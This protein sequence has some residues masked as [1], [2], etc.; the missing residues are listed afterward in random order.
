MSHSPRRRVFLCNPPSGLYRRDDRCQS[1][2]EDQTVRVIF[3]PIDLALLAAIAR[4][5][6]AAVLLRDYPAD[7]KSDWETL[8]RDIREFAPDLVL[9]N[10]TS[11]T[12]EADMAVVRI[13]REES[14]TAL[15]I[16]RGEHFERMGD[17]LFTRED[18]P[19][20]ALH[21]EIEEN[22]DALLGGAPP[23]TLS[24]VLYRDVA[25]GKFRRKPGPAIVENLDALPIPAREFLDN[26]RYL[27]PETGRPITVILANRGCPSKCVYCPAGVLSGHRLRARSPQSVVGEI[28][29]C[30]ERHGVREFLFNGDTFTMNRKW[31]LELC[32]LI[33]EARLDIRWGCNSRVDTMDEERAAALKSAGCWVVAFGV[34]SG[35]QEM[36]DRMKKGTRLEQARRAI[37]VCKRAGLATHAFF[38]IGLPWENRE[39]LGRTFR[40]A[41]ELDTDFFD[42]NIAHPLPGTEF[43]EIAKAENLIV[44]EGDYAHAAVRTLYLSAE[45]LTR[46]R[47]RALLRLYFRPGYIWKTL[48]RAKRDGTLPHYLKAALGRLKGLLVH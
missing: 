28:R 30:V 2:V 11:A 37:D 16:A 47:R 27:S 25:T 34:E 22:F 33:R 39:T 24:A 23:E 26:R 19:D 42:I 29:E 35:D 8:R 9:F 12:V 31:I 1:R 15:I 40:F 38:I 14:S 41:K 17:N 3:P 46:W 21:G 36:L 32:G 20:L 45:E 43:Y 18:G 44:G 7:P 4:S 5:R 13:A 10:T 48:R 6:Q